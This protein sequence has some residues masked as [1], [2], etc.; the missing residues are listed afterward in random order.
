MTGCSATNTTD[1]LLYRSETST[2]RVTLVRVLTC[3]TMEDAL[4][5]LAHFV[6]GKQDARI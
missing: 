5:D 2:A 1:K 6:F 3:W 4:I